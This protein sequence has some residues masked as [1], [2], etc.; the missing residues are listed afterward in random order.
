MPFYPIVSTTD[1]RSASGCVPLV[2]RNC[3]VEPQPQ[4]GAKRSNQV[5]TPCMGRV[6]RVTP[7]AG[8]NIRGVF[9][10][11]G[12]QDGALFV[13]AG[14]T[15][16][17]ISTN[18]NATALGSI[19]GASGTVLFDSIG[20]KL[21]VLAGGTVYEY[22]GTSLT[23]NT[24]PDCP[25]NA[26]TLASLADRALTS[27]QG[28]DQFDWSGTGSALTWPSSGFASSARQP[29]EIRNQ[30]VVAGDLW[31]FGAATAQVWRAMGGDDADAFDILSLV[32]D[33][34]IIGRDAIAKIDS[35]LMWVGEDRVVYLMNGYTPM[36]VSNREIELA[37][38]ELTEAQAAGLQCFSYAQGSHLTWVL[39]MPSGKSYC[40]NTLSRTWGERAT[41]RL[42]GQSERYAPTYH[43]Y[44]NA[45]GAHVVASDADDTIFTWEA[46]TYTDA[47]M[48]HERIMMV[49]V[50]AAARTPVANVTLDLK[51]TDVPLTGTGSDPVAQ[52]TFYTDG[53]S[54]DSLATRGVERIVKLGKRGAFAQ[55]P[56]I[57]RLGT[58]N[59]A[60]G[61]IL[62]IRITDPINFSFSGVWV[63]EMPMPT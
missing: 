4:G 27:A 11:P 49:H 48:P 34:G 37:L 43:T 61:L 52:V 39:R 2:L 32:I 62:K 55:R 58:V 7:S 50:P 21:T 5:I 56:T 19:Q 42:P 9:S 38:A 26:Y 14:S 46:D 53:G 59:A 15:L 24:D 33:R 16:Y 63:N 57:W 3:V 44:F 6:S 8:Q 36:R 47:D 30:S 31:H 1:D 28:S 45:A 18:W 41:W 60:D 10:R 25:L 12:V 22:D 51:C 40:Y 29:D 23:A 35:S 20:T 17:R 13:A 54:R